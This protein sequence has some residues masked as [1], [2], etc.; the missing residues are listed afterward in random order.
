M[1][2]KNESRIPDFGWASFLKA[3]VPSYFVPL[4]MSFQGGYFSK[5]HDLMRASY[6]TIA[7]PSL[8]STAF[9]FLLLMQFQKHQIMMINK[10][11]LALTLSL[12]MGL[13]AFQAIAIFGLQAFIL[14]I[15]PS[16]MLGAIVAT[17]TNPLKK[18]NFYYE[19]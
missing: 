12:A 6:S 13:I 5:N 8:L 11:A 1:K 4:V 15:V 19:N 17:L 16:S 14:D 18:I 7:T 10:F 2:K 9:C 3:T